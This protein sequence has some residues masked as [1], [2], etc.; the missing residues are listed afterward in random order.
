MNFNEKENADYLNNIPTQ[1][2]CN[3]ETIDV[4]KEQLTTKDKQIER[5]L[6]IIESKK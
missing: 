3:K 2:D 5:L 1:N 4:L 6:K